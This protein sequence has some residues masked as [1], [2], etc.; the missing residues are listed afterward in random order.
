MRDVTV[1][2]LGVE[3]LEDRSLPADMG[4]FASGGMES[5]APLADASIALRSPASRFLPPTVTTIV[6][7]RL[8][9]APVVLLMPNA[10]RGN[11]PHAT[12]IP[13]KAAPRAEESTL[14]YP[15]PV[16]PKEPELPEWAP[17]VEE[18]AESVS[19]KGMATLTPES[20]ELDFTLVETI[21]LVVDA[22]V[23]RIDVDNWKETATRL[24]DSL[25]SATRD[26][27]APESPWLRIGYWVVS[28]GA[29]GVAVEWARQSTRVRHP[30]NETPFLLV[31]R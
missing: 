26:P 5:F 8:P 16:V 4:F 28:I 11:D 23:T 24:L 10:L 29:V 22:L 2:R 19:P 25:E 31:R 15:P 18:Q 27:L 3:S 1:R 21:P 13:V 20:E 12:A 7:H 9:D 14:W 17:P 30:H 6:A